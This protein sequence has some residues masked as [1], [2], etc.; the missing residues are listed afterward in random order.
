MSNLCSKILFAKDN[1]C[2]VSQRLVSHVGH[3]TW[4]A[5]PWSAVPYELKSRESRRARDVVCSSL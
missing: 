3:E 1:I 4:S 5:V 2:S